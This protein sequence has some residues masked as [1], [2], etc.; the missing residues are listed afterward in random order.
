VLASERSREA[1]WEAIRA[2]RTYATTG[3]RLLL[4]VS[5][6]LAAGGTGGTETEQEAEAHPM[7]AH[8]P[9]ERSGSGPVR[10]SAAVHGTAP[11]W[12]AEV[13]R[14]PEVL[15]RHP[16]PAPEPGAERHA[17]RIG[18]TGARIRAR[19]RMTDWAG[20]LRVLDG[21]ARIVGATGWGFDQPEDGICER[22]P[23]HVAWRSS[24]AGDWDGITVLLEGDGAATL[25]FASRPA[26]FRFT[27]GD[28]AAGAVEV[29]AGGVGQRVVVEPDPGK[30]QPRAVTMEVQDEPPAGRS[31]YLV[32]VTQQD[33]QVGWSSPIVV[34][35]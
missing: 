2:R 4:D 34:D 18:W 17:L 33:G 35:R 26:T 27:P 28:A 20:S 29:D 19:Q 9:R 15:Y 6:R 5:L 31:Y 10:L 21:R 30:A 25:E 13:L 11:L 7:G 14:W 8:L 22:S 24:T 3:A 32:R 12:R 23:A 16:L 1:V